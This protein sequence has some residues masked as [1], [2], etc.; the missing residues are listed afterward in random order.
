MT[1]DKNYFLSRLNKGENIDDIGESIAAM[2]T[3]AI[4]EYNAA[5]KAEEAKK[6][7]EAKELA[8]KRDLG[9]RMIDIVREY[10]DIVAPGCSDSFKECDDED[11]DEM[12]GMLDQLFN[13]YNIFDKAK[14]TIVSDKDNDDELL[15]NFLAS[16]FNV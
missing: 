14:M 10:A 4:S 6:A 1:I 13:L 7:A 12:I 16:I 2:M 3:D 9:L 11:L 15:S 8:K 5:K